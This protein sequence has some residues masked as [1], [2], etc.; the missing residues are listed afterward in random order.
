[1]NHAESRR[2]TDFF[3][4]L[5][6]VKGRQTPAQT[7]SGSRRA[8]ATLG[9]DLRAASWDAAAALALSAVVFGLLMKALGDGVDAAAVEMPDMVRNGGVWPYSASQAFGWAGLLWSWLAVVIGASLP[10]LTRSGRSP[11]RLTLERLHRSMGLTLVA[12]M[13][14]HAILL[15]WDRMGD[16]LVSDFVPWANSYVPGRFAQALGIFS[17]YLAVLL[18]LT[19]YLRDRIGAAA[20]RLIHRY[21]VPAVYVLALWHTF[22]YGSDLKKHELLWIC[23]WALQAPIAAA[24]A[25]RVSHVRI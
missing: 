7:Q 16:T 19:F 3:N 24:Y 2:A 8:P 5:L 23:L 21:G 13:F 4:S 15:V 11:L 6:V 12:L 10:V 1:M 14:A 20:W 18:G 22:A 25:L 9:G 17:F